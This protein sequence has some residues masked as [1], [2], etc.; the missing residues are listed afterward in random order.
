M[1]IWTVQLIDGIYYSF[2]LYIPTASRIIPPI[3]NPI[4]EP[5]IVPKSS[6]LYFTTGSPKK[7]KNAIAAIKQIIPPAISSLHFLSCSFSTNL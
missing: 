4:D 2:S 6:P 1:N 5:I 3:P 7:N